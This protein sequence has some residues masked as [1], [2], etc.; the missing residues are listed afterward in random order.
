[1]DR[2]S[3]RWWSLC[4]VLA[5]AVAIA[6]PV[7]AGDIKGSLG[8]VDG[9]R[10]LRV[11]GTPEERGFA[12]GYLLGKGFPRLVE[13]ALTEGLIQGGPEGYAERVLPLVKTMKFSP[14]HKAE[15]RGLVAGMEAAGNGPVIIE[16]LGRALTAEDIEAMNCLG[17]LTL[18]GCSSFS[19][20][21]KMTADGQTVSG[22]N[23]DWHMLEALQGAQVVVVYP[24]SE[25]GK[26]LGWVSI[27]W[28][29]YIAGITAMNSEGVT[30]SMHDSNGFPPSRQRGL[31]PRGFALRRAAETARAKTAWKDVKKALGKYLP[32]VG[33][34]IHVTVPY[35]GEDAP[36]RVFEYDGYREKDR[37]ITV[38]G[39]VGENEFLV[40]TNHFRS[41]KRPGRCE[42]F[43]ILSDWLTG[44]SGQ[45]EPSPV[46]ME[47]AWGKLGE[48]PAQ[49]NL[50][51]HSVVFE[52]A[53]R[54]MRVALTEGG[55]PAPQC[56]KVVLD[57][58]ELLEGGFPESTAGE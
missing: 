19:A 41:R 32:P 6:A 21:C 17:D 31:T 8:E 57:V 34:N 58:A 54:V 5:L 24:P 4:C 33:G 14:D 7:Y 11:W 40:C 46:R 55:R 53:K 27:T 16:A 25:D 37:G 52:P 20:W 44:L 49:G 3:G 28:P 43:A 42:R 38:R 10:V 2:L 56:R 39:P 15:M 13:A 30:L 12:Q 45:T 9:V 48:V 36:A 35:D 1:M 23:M 47:E 26:R 51:F 18:M 22:R 29:G 50:C